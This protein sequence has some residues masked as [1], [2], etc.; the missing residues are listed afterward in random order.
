MNEKKEFEPLDVG[1][2]ERLDWKVAQRLSKYVHFDENGNVIVDKN[3]EVDGT[4]KLNGGLVPVFKD[5]FE[6][7]NSEGTYKC[8]FIDYGEFKDLN[9][10]ILYF[11]F[12]DGASQTIG[13]GAYYV[14]NNKVTSFDI[15]GVSIIDEQ[16]QIV[17]LPN[18][19][20]GT[21]PTYKSVVT[22]P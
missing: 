12:N 22:R 9:I 18:T 17:S 11:D 5:S 2:T 16:F 4:T 13:L 6:L 14:D 10:H 15:Y 1:A 21:I 7:Q 19:N 3:L 20:L 8:T